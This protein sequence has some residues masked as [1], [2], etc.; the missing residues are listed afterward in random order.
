M[1]TL[2]SFQRTKIV[3]L[4]ELKFSYGNIIKKVGCS[5]SSVDRV[6]KKFQK[7]NTIDDLARP[8]ICSPRDERL[9]Y[10]MSMNNRRLTAPKIDNFELLSQP[11]AIREHCEE[12]FAKVW[13]FW[14]NC[15]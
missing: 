13:A 1:T 12:N 3:V 14:E 4:R 7:E 5:K 9:I 2:N 10:R 15:T 8:R 11:A 6:Y